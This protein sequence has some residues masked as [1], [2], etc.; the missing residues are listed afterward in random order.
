LRRKRKIDRQSG[1][2]ADTNL[3]VIASEDEYAVK[4][5]FNLF[6]SV[7]IQFE[8]LETEEGKS[9]PKNVLQRLS[10]YMDDFQIGEGDEFWLVTDIDHWAEPG[11]IKNLAEVVKLCRQKQIG[12]ATSFPC[13]DLWL[14]LHFSEIPD[15]PIRQCSEIAS[16]IRTA[17][18]EYNKTKVFNL[19]I[20]MDNVEQAIRRA[21]DA[22][23]RGPI[24]E[25]LGSEVYLII[26][27]LVASKSISIQ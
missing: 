12:V 7:R 4:Q 5:Y 11:H 25:E 8:I 1:K 26:E 16:L 23:T 15:K 20:A 9:S 17:A 13:F 2:L 6:H 14:L 22:E 10:R 24:L 21:K 27:R 19:P 18:G 3:I